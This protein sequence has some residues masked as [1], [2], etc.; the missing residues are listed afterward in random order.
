MLAGTFRSSLRE[1]TP[2]ES[3]EINGDIGTKWANMWCVAQFGTK[4]TI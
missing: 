3:I 2:K 4:Y 1:N